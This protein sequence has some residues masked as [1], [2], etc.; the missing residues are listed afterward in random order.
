MAAGV[1]ARAKLELPLFLWLAGCEGRERRQGYELGDKARRYGVPVIP[2]DGGT[3][4][5]CTGW[6]RSRWDGLEAGT[7]PVLIE[8]REFRLEGEGGRAPVD[9]LAQMRG[10]LLGRKVCTTAWLEGAG[11]GLRRRIA[12]AG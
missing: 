5:R 12:V 4:W 10:F 3:R 1:G 9:P 8:C 6:R 11:D 2:V 7:E